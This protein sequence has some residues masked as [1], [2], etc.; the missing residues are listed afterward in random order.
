MVTVAIAGATGHVGKTIAEV[1]QDDSKH[2]LI[3]LSRK[4]ADSKT[5]ATPVIT[6]NYDDIDSLVDTLE[7]N[8]IHTIISA[9]LVKDAE[10]SGSE[11][12]LVRAASR[13]SVTKRFIASDY[14]API[15]EMKQ[16]GRILARRATAQE[17]HKTSL[18]WT[19]IRVG[20]FA[21]HLGIPHIKSYM[22]PVAIN[23]DVANRAAAIP[24]SGNDLIVYTYSFDMAKF[25]VAALDL[26]KWDRDLFCY[27]DKTTVNQIVELAEEARG[28]KF[29]VA[30]DSVEKLNRGEMTEL[31]SHTSVYSMIPKETIQGNFSK[32][33]LYALDGLFD[34]PEEN[35]LNAKFPEIKTMTMADML[36]F[37]RGK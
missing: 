9:I 19:T 21:D 35:T 25:V 11:V 8:D 18:E 27:S 30:Y 33:S 4:K 10:S 14:A 16:F 26:P 13:S 32:Y 15:P 20:Q 36:G 7:K 28:S 5:S 34:F 22:N 6:V 2:D 31:P 17:L 24:G 37:W 1:L 3:I 12:A 23:V 29:D